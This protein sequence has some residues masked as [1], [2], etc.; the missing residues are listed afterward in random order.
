MSSVDNPFDG[1]AIAQPRSYGPNRAGEAALRLMR[2][3]PWGVCAITA[4]AAALRF[5]ELDDVVGNPFYDASVHSMGLSWHNF[6]FGAFDPGA[7]LSVDKPPLDLWLQVATVKLFGW[8]S[9]ALKLPEALGGTLAVPLLYDA[10]RR[11]VGRG[12]GLAAG[13]AL[14]VMPI[15]VLTSR[16]DTMDSLMMLC[17]VGALWLTVR[18]TARGARRW[19][20]LAGVALGLAFNVKLTEG[21]VAVPAL[22][23]LYAVA[24]P[25]PWR[26]RIADIAL[27]G[28]ALVIVAL[29]WAVIVTLAPGRHPFPIG[30]TNGGVFD[31]IFN[32]N[33]YGRVA[34]TLVAGGTFSAPPGVFRLLSSVG[35]LGRLF[36]AMLV[37]AV[38]LGAAAVVVNLRLRSDEE[39]QRS[40]RLAFAFSLAV[41]VWLVCGVAVLSYVSLLHA[42]YLEMVTPAVAAAL[43][44]GLASL[45]AAA[46]RSDLRARAAVI[47]LGA[48]LAG[49]CWYISSLASAPVVI[50]AAFG[51]AAIL[52]ATV[53]S[54]V[55]HLA[56]PGWSLAGVLA[57][58]CCLTFSVWES[59]AI[60]RGARS[61][62]VGLAVQPRAIQAA[63]SRYLL[64]R[65]RGLRYELAVDD[66]IK[67]APLIIH[68]ARP[69]LPLTSFGAQP[70][71]GLAELQ[72]AAR[73]GAVRYGLVGVYSCLGGRRGAACVPTSLWI[74]HYGIDVSAQA[75][76]PAAMRLHLYRLPG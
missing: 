35:S 9:F 65:T 14:A 66:P 53:A 73:S 47:A 68:D 43:G 64:P 26:R 4:I 22:V 67:L 57:L 76:I 74:R 1:L 45:V 16:S 18:A 3:M 54:L 38:A 24:A 34:G 42:R 5:A 7:T 69:I 12:A 39:D 75:G 32:F 13:I 63:I 31:V 44:C 27:A 8:S 37:C 33:G 25:V 61:D 2:A 20:V 49:V 55:R 46:L 60:V 19:L 59:D 17:V 56:R 72:R 21:L 30:S 29:S 50:A 28:G 23:L 40:R 11:A 52:A 58:A 51:G 48:A 62:S 41:F 70:L 10:V 6:L 15:S 36:G 71:V